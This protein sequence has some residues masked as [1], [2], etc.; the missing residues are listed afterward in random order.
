MSRQGVFNFLEEA[1]TVFFMTAGPVLGAV[2]ALVFLVGLIYGTF[3]I[4][5]R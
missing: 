5:F 2:I 4:L 1:V 3:Y